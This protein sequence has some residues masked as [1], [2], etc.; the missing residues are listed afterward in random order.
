M[1]RRCPAVWGVL[2]L[3]FSGV[4]SVSAQYYVA[5]LGTLGGPTGSSYAQAVNAD[6]QVVGYATD[7]GG[8]EHA[9][10]YSAGTG[11]QDL[12]V[13]LGA[14]R[15]WATGINGSRQVVGYLSYSDAGSD[16]Y[17]G[18]LYSVPD[19]VKN[20]GTL[21]GGTYSVA[22]GINT[23]GQV[24]GYADNSK[25]DRRA[26]SLAGPD[27]KLKDLG[28]LGGRSSVASAIDNHGID[29]GQIVGWSETST[30][31]T[32]AF[33]FT[34]SGG[35]QDVGTLPGA[36]VGGY[37]MAHATN[38]NWLVVGESSSA[39]GAAHAFLFNPMLGG[40][41]AMRDLGVLSGGMASC[42]LGINN[43]VQVVGWS[44]YDASGAHHAFLCSN[45]SMIDLNSAISQTLGW[46]L[47]DATAVNSA[48]QIVGFGT[49]GKSGGA[50]AFLLTPA[51][52]GDANL[53][54]SVN[55]TDLNTVLSNYN[56]TAM[57]WSQGDFNYDGTVNGADLN[58]VLSNYNQ[59]IALSGVGAAV[60]EP[61]TLLLTVTGLAALLA[62]APRN[63]PRRERAYYT[64]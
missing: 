40:P 52:S 23:F 17:T 45:G 57:N 7:S 58:T 12:G 28:T 59:S 48:G 39:S 29:T 26:V 38:D 2:C 46:T 20:L 51:L 18:F 25:G 27:D 5:N 53:D 32:H 6:G 22:L 47:T 62:I 15:S 55:G 36:P 64:R 44:A 31:R 37:S 30:G 34:V 43:N 3:A 14:S 1:L 50:R 9:F 19:G 33:L 56:G 21:D 49:I 54:G 8:I 13:V 11:M 60:P 35:M 24:V 63:V 4:G 16:N 61:S 10:L 41:I 42:A